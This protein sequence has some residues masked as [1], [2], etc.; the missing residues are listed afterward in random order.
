MEKESA[1]TLADKIRVHGREKCVSRAKERG[2]ARF[3][4]RAGDVVHDLGVNGRVPAVCSALRTNQFL[5]E[6]GLRLVE[7]T[8]PKSGQST[9]VTFTYEFIDSK[10]FRRQ[11]GDAWSRLRGAL[12]D[13]LSELGGGE[14][15]LRSERGNF[16]RSGEHE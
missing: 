6:N 8:G 1:M 12:K 9:T 13:V 4:I 15:Y 3:A 14:A 10:S 5:K 16:H 11:E 2:Q 7:I